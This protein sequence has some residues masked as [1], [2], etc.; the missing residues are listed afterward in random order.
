MFP[1]KVSSRTSEGLSEQTDRGTWDVVQLAE[2]LPR[3]SEV[4]V[5]PTAVCKT[6]VLVNACNLN[7][8]E[9]T[10]GESMVRGHPWL[11]SWPA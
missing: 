4:A 6:G 9:V 11:Y 3:I 8:L 5:S 7:N 10:A 1:I 2:C